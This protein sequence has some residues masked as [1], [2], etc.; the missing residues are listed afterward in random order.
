MA[1]GDENLQYYRD[2]CNQHVLDLIN[3]I[4]SYIKSHLKVQGKIMKEQCKNFTRDRIVPLDRDCSTRSHLKLSVLEK[5]IILRPLLAKVLP[6]DAP[7]NLPELD[8]EFFS[9]CA[10]VMREI[11]LVAR[12]LE[13][14]NRI[15]ASRLP[16]RLYE[17]RDALEIFSADRI[18][19]QK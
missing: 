16:R 7:S 5:Y 2:I 17:L 4:G 10:F 3:S 14:D 13:A 9:K 19:P 8:G 1:S 15:Y 11:R 18:E 12:A 6:D